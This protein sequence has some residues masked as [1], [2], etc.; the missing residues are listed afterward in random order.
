MALREL[1]DLRRDA[2]ELR[3][4]LARI[5]LAFARGTP[6]PLTVPRVVSS[7]RMACSRDGLA[8][9]VETLSAADS[10][11]RAARL[12][13][14][15]D[16]LVRAR[17]LDLEPQAA[18]EALEIPRRPAVRL[19]G[20]PGL[21]G[22]LPPIAVERDL[23]FV[24]GREERADMESALAAAERS[25]AGGIRS[26]LWE[27]AESALSELGRGEPADAA[28]V[29][30][31]RGWA[32]RPPPE[33]SQPAASVAPPRDVAPAKSSLVRGAPPP[34]L[35]Q[36]AVT[37][38]CDR[39]LR[40]TDAL[41]RDLGSWLIERHTGARAAPGGAERHDLLHFLYAPRFAGAFPRGELIRTVRRWA[42][43][44]RLDLGAG[45]SISL[46][47]EERPLQ[48][49]GSRV[50]A[51]DPPHEV[52]IVLRPAEGPRALALLLACVGRA[53]LRAG[54]PP[55]AP[56]E[57]L[58]LGD[59]ALEPACGALLAGLLL[60]GTW[61]R[62]CAQADLPPDDQ[63]G[64]AVAA[65]LDA[66]LEAAR[67]LASLQALREGFGARAEHAYR[68]L[69]ARAALADIPAALAARELDPLLGPWADL[70]GR[71][72]AAHLRDFLRERFDEDWWRNPR[73]LPALQGLWA[74]GGRPTA[75]E[76]WA[77]AGGT[78]SLT[79]LTA[80]LSR[81]CA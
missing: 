31:E 28:L 11:G 15:R 4:D 7:H 78:P 64:L 50:V 43:M 5:E 56:P 38:A 68:E 71:A 12:A 40:D 81:A 55:D 20:D 3:A 73:A 74:R 49:G 41:A 9:A 48:P 70:R 54:P 60:D 14:L 80:E 17:A 24:R 25:A 62:R 29:L 76:L 19:S 69:H 75:A 26:A 67:A 36:D 66:R 61:V 8:Q 46:E 65:L 18:Q 23:P 72:L 57:D 39:F 2:A 59:L 45:G 42:G 37:S 13:S 77:E 51:V 22:A 21:H 58:W 32:P 34:A 1:I 6:F 63:R 44:L 47:E 16:F 30:H 53:Q 10:P 33:T 79:P 52:R 35:E 27:A